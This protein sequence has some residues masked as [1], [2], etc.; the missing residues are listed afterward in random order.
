MNIVLEDDNTPKRGRAKDS[1]KRGKRAEKSPRSGRSLIKKTGGLKST[2]KDVVD[3]G[4][5]DDF[6]PSALSDDIHAGQVSTAGQ[7]GDTLEVPTTAQSAAG[8]IWA[9]ADAEHERQLQEALAQHQAQMKSGEEGH[10]LD[11]DVVGPGESIYAEVPPTP[12]APATANEP[13]GSE[14]GEAEQA[15]ASAAKSDAEDVEQVEDTVATGE[16]V[17]GERDV[18][19]TKSSQSRKDKK[20]GARTARKEFRSKKG[21]SNS[22]PKGQK[23]AKEAMGGD[24]TLEDTGESVASRGS[25]VAS[26]V[27]LLV[28]TFAA[29]GLAYVLG[30]QLALY[31]LAQLTAKAL[32]G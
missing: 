20:A 26:L 22:K 10:E 32:G 12:V 2:A 8:D 4:P 19:P 11:A 29:G 13:C 3:A 18:T 25:S 1:G 31:Q 14:V 17:I 9:E 5:G 7:T 24:G 16:E 27:L 28:G 21:T 23:V 15:G 6:I 30:G